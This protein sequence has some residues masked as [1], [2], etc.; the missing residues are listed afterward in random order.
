MREMGTHQTELTGGGGG[1]KERGK[2]EDVL[3][4]KIMLIVNAIAWILS[5][6]CSNLFPHFI[7]HIYIFIKSLAICTV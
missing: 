1:E 7:K 6:F 4:R 3:P 5:N 2:L